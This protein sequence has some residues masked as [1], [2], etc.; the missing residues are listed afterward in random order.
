[1]K[2]VNDQYVLSNTDRNRIAAHARAIARRAAYT[3]TV[4]AWFD[5]STGQIHYCELTS[6]GCMEARDDDMENI[7][8]AYCRENI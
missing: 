5:R 6:G 1:M 8:T 4:E 2:K 7:Y 3:G